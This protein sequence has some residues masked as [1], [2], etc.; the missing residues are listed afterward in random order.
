MKKLPQFMKL[1][2]L[3]DMYSCYK[4][5][6]TNGKSTRNEQTHLLSELAHLI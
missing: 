6:M 2:L 3:D 5:I 4:I 1:L